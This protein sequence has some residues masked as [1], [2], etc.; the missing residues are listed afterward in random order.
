MRDLPVTFVHV[1]WI[2][3]SVIEANFY[4]KDIPVLHEL[5]EN[6]I[7]FHKI[8]MNDSCIKISSII[9]QISN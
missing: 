1:S 8:K 2:P 6:C 4:Q 9:A 7:N 3:P 5:S